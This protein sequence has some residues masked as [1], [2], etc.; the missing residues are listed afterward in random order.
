MEAVAKLSA[1]RSSASKMRQ[2]VNLVR[3]RNIFE[4]LNILSYSSKHAAIPVEKLIRSAIANWEAKTG[5]SAGGDQF[6]KL[7]FVDEGVTIKRFRPAPMGR[8]T[9]IRKRSSHVTVVI[10]SRNK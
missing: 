3:G 2:V 10:G 5:L 7:A 6:I 1:Y 4:A 9:R 8:A